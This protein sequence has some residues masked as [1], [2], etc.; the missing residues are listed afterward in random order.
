MS[1]FRYLSFVTVGGSDTTICRAA[2]GAEAKNKVWMEESGSR[3]DGVSECRMRRTFIHH[4]MRAWHTHI[5]MHRRA[6]C[7]HFIPHLLRPPSTTSICAFYSVSN[8]IHCCAQSCCGQQK[9]CICGIW[10]TVNVFV[11]FMLC[12]LSKKASCNLLNHINNS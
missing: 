3:W 1:V 9:N 5:H 10:V 2:R 11:A 12:I 8:W 7:T 6:R 4:S